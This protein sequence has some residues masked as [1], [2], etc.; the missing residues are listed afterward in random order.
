MKKVYYLTFIA[1]FFTLQA[2]FAATENSANDPE[3]EMIEISTDGSESWTPF[4]MI[5]GHAPFEANWGSITFKGGVPVGGNAAVKMWPDGN[6]QFIGH[7]HDSGAPSYNVAILFA[8]TGHNGYVL[9]FSHTGHMAGTFESGSRDN[10]WNN[11]GRNDYIRTHWAEFAR[12]GWKGNAHTGL[13]VGS[14]WN[15][16]KS[17]IG[18]V[19][20]VVAIVGSL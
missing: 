14:L 16:L 2:A 18:T 19:K 9:T 17:A 4:S 1:S 6:Y 20:E 11:T 15:S 7:F 12:A 3:A 5:E 10:D 13:D 8:V